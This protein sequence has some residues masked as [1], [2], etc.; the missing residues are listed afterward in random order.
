MRV[1]QQLFLLAVVA[2]CALVSVAEGLSVAEHQRRFAELR[3]VVHNTA[4]H[5]VKGLKHSVKD[6]HWTEEHDDV[7]RGVMEQRDSMV[8]A[9]TG[10]SLLETDTS[11]SN[12]PV[13]RRMR[14]R[15][16]RGLLKS[17]DEH[18]AFIETSELSQVSKGP[19]GKLKKMWKSFRAL[20]KS[21]A[22]FLRDDVVEELYVGVGAE[23][24]I[25][26]KGLLA[27][28]IGPNLQICWDATSYMNAAVFDDFDGYSKVMEKYRGKVTAFVESNQLYH[29]KRSVFDKKLH[30]PKK[31]TGQMGRKNVDKDLDTLFGKFKGDLDLKDENNSTESSWH[32][33][34]SSIRR[35]A[36]SPEDFMNSEAMNKTIGMGKHCA[37]EAGMVI[38]VCINI[39]WRFPQ[40]KPSPYLTL[41]MN[42]KL[43][44]CL[45]H[46]GGRALL[47]QARKIGPKTNSFIDGAL[48]QMDG[49]LRGMRSFFEKLPTLVDK[50]HFK[51][52]K[53]LVKHSKL[54]GKKQ[55]GKQLA[56]MAKIGDK[57]HLIVANANKRKAKYVQDRQCEDSFQWVFGLLPRVG[58]PSGMRYSVRKCQHA[59][60]E[61]RGSFTQLMKTA[62]QSFRNMLNI[63]NTN[64]TKLLSE[65]MKEDTSLLSHALEHP[66]CKKVDV[67]HEFTV[68][69]AAGI[70]K[71]AFRLFAYSAVGAKAL[72]GGKGAFDELDVHHAKNLILHEEISKHAGDPED[73]PENFLELEGLGP[74]DNMGV[75]MSNIMNL[76]KM[77]KLKQFFLGLLP[78]G[79]GLGTTV[80]IGPMRHAAPCVNHV[81]KTFVLSTFKA[82][83]LGEC[84][85]PCSTDSDCSGD[86]ICQPVLGSFLLP[87]GQK[88]CIGC[89]SEGSI[90]QLDSDC[91]TRVCDGSYLHGMVTG[92]CFTP[93]PE[94]GT[95]DANEQC[96]S[97]DCDGHGFGAFW[98]KCDRSSK[99]L[100]E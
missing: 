21:I 59:L 85:S 15:K 9:F 77:A 29:N 22:E 35:A 48:R 20:M 100:E 70:L 53:E 37:K 65:D 18:H 87:K 11:A 74:L 14:E 41:V 63:P 47:E 73:L 93:L 4:S 62:A 56:N 23:G 90:C 61:K 1:V 33:I 12:E 44:S 3:D 66:A 46:E 43:L 71:H 54:V 91:D 6:E 36:T 82:V 27:S 31:R 7:V 26:W 34:T 2:C 28:G 32:L 42:K 51:A 79:I 80:S 8:S 40:P 84:K 97:G 39:N 13:D 89:K 25:G 88:Y 58:K 30:A 92:K 72:E 76:G 99:K 16:F 67:Q 49:G 81:I 24:Y 94:G 19:I 95:C 64:E 38:K 83:V 86:A 78:D 50:A 68:T 57:A 55:T 75:G 96:K 45:S 10:I 98:G 69:L 52:E 17:I 5:I 60:G